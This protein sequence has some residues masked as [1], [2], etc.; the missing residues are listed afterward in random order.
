[1]G[2]SPDTIQDAGNAARARPSVARSARGQGPDPG[3]LVLTDLG[4]IAPSR[5]NRCVLRAY[6]SSIQRCL[7]FGV[8][9]LDCARGIAVGPPAVVPCRHIRDLEPRVRDLSLIRFGQARAVFDHRSSTSYGRSSGDDDRVLLTRGK[10]PTEHAVRPSSAPRYSYS[11]HVT[12]RPHR[13]GCVLLVALPRCLAAGP[14]RA[15]ALSPR[16]LGGRR[17]LGYGAR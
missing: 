17:G 14:W 7:Q 12:E 16:H 2:W 5:R 10:D 9:E 6:G 13:P 15:N 8:T 4:V 1:S 3:A 11:G